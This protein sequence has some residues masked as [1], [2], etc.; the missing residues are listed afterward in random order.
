RSRPGRGAGRL[1][2]P[3]PLVTDA[4]RRGFARRGCEGG[5]GAVRPGLGRP[6]RE[7]PQG[8]LLLEGDPTGSLLRHEPGTC[9]RWGRSPP[10]TPKTPAH[11]RAAQG[12]LRNSR[13]QARHRR[14]GL[15]GTNPPRTMLEILYEDNHCLAVNKPAGLLTQGD[16][17]GD[18]TLIDAARADLK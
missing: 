9:P 4:A 11:L 6:P 8:R 1:P 18:P 15:T 10:R 5:P 12:S 17:T 14:R 2:S 13:R 3:P 7:A 16:A